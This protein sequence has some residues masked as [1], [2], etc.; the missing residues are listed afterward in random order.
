MYKHQLYILLYN[1]SK[2]NKINKL[3][4]KQMFTTET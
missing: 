4:G 1:Y 3:K 2:W